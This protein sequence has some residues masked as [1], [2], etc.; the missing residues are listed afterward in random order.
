MT[1]LVGQ[2]LEVHGQQILTKVGVRCIYP[3]A[4][5]PRNI[6]GHR[7]GLITTREWNF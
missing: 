4:Q 3:T 5:A 7:S 6:S 2:V 1:D